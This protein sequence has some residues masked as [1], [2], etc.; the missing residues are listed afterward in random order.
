MTD[1]PSGQAPEA[2][3]PSEDRAALVREDGEGLRLA[4]ARGYYLEDLSK[5]ALADAFGLS[6]FRVA[7]LLQEARRQGLVRIEVG[8]AGRVDREISAAL[9]ELLGVRRAVVVGT[10]GADPH[11]ALEHVGAAMADQLV[12]EVA[13][14]DVL[15]ITWSAAITVMAE[16]LH[17]LSPLPRCQVLQLGGAVYP[18]AG[19]PGSVEV[20]RQVAA[21][22][23]VTAEAIYSP[24][25]V[26]DSQTADGLRRQPEIAAVL[27]AARGL[28]VAV[29]SVGS[30]QPSRSAVY[31]LLSPA[32][33]EALAE[34][35][36]C[37]E[38]SGRLFDADGRFLHT[39][40]D[41]R[42]V[43]ID[44]RT[45]AGVPRL[46]VSSHGA[47]RAD[48]TRAAVRAG[49]VHTLVCDADLAVAL[50]ADA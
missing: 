2:G 6:R 1:G 27:D 26:P 7:R 8:A 39:P 49:L 15:G 33:A 9:Q 20:A 4:L 37:G 22:A 23:G 31:D 42:V 12:A 38:V 30:W 10:A 18:P 25:V 24:L 5:V 41:E 19:M 44:A 28:D 48:A 36:V 40:L 11:S 13:E 32:E 35:G 45:L 29:L 16:R 17:R 50:L 46:L 21:A 47:H 14:N 34:A 43:G 3:S